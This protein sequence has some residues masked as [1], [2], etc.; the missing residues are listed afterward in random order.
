MCSNQCKNSSL[1]L[2]S[3]SSSW[4][5]SWSLAS[6]RS[7]MRLMVLAI[8]R[9]EVLVVS[10]QASKEM[11]GGEKSDVS[12][13]GVPFVV[14]DDPSSRDAGGNRTSRRR[15]G[16]RRPCRGR[17]SVLP[18]H[19]VRAAKKRER[20]PRI[21]RTCCWSSGESPVFGGASPRSTRRSYRLSS[22]KASRC[23]AESSAQYRRISSAVRLSRI[24]GLWAIPSSRT[25]IV[26]RAI[27]SVATSRNDVLLSSSPSCSDVSSGR[28]NQSPALDLV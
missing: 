7:V 5:C 13:D 15:A 2:G 11:T 26:P 18:R 10:F 8:L 14:G 20:C 6:S 23:S 24:D 12:V 9:E 22:R 25:R 3:A 27:P 4:P 19:A 16:R 21:D 28:S 1:S 17:S